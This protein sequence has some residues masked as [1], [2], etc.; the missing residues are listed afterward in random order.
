MVKT[1]NF[2]K[3]NCLLKFPRLITL[4]ERDRTNMA[5]TIKKRL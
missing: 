1:I 2:Y 5:R 4:Y 3:I